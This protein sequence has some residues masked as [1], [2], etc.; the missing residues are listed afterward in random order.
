[1]EE[2]VCRPLEPDV[3]LMV[4]IVNRPGRYMLWIA[5]AAEVRYRFSGFLQY[6]GGV[7]LFLRSRHMF[8]QGED[9]ARHREGHVLQEG[10]MRIGDYHRI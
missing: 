10:P 1:M 2:E 6:C 9:S 7:G 4:H 8:L 3:D 5:A